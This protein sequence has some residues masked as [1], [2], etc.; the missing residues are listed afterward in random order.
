MKLQKKSLSLQLYLWIKIVYSHKLKKRD[1]DLIIGGDIISS[2][3]FMSTLCEICRKITIFLFAVLSLT[4]ILGVLIYFIEEETGF[5]S[6]SL[7][8][9][10][11]ITTLLSAGYGDAVLQTDLGRL[12]AL[13]IRALGSCIIIVPFIVVIT[14]ICK[15][16][17]K[18]L[19]GKNCQLK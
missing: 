5:T 2:R 6:P 19:F 10:W 3:L 14:E 16:L 7:S 15:L 1:S 18:T 17:Y 8:I 11:A 9:Y 12:V 4:I 13:F